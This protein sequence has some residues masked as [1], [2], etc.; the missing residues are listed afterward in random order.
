MGLDGTIKRADGQALG[1]V[2][3][4]QQALAKVFPGICFGRLPSGKE[5]I[6]AAVEKG[7][8]LPDALLKYLETSSA[9]LGAEYEGSD[10]SAQFNLG[11]SE[12]VQEVDIVL[13]GKTT[14]SD[15][16]FELLEEQFGWITTHP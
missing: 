2:S 13:Y 10:F 12:T 16:N 11:S 6:R 14:R 1:N 5:R 15:P 3:F 4:V 8:V 7:V 9:N